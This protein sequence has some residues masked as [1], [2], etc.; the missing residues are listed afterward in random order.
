[1]RNRIRRHWLPALTE[2]FNPKLLRALGDLAEAQRRDGEWIEEQVAGE[3][4][5]RF[6]ME[7]SWLRIDTRNWERLPEALARRLAREALVR[8][9]SGRHV[10]RRHLERMLSFLRSG[11]SGSA[12]ELPGELL[13]CRE[14]GMFRLGP[15]S[16][17]AKSGPP[18]AC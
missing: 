14:N 8:C 17:A 12:I 16:P 7:G 4:R 6:S 11:R 13:L 3:A 2:E 5:A 9:G 10:T 18:G 1:L 15:G